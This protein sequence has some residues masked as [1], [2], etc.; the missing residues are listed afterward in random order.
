MFEKKLKQKE[1]MINNF[2]KEDI[3][4][5]FKVNEKEIE[6]LLQEY[7]IN[8][9][10]S[11]KEIRNEIVNSQIFLTQFV[12]IP[13]KNSKEPK[14]ENE[15]NKNTKTSFFNR[16]VSVLKGENE[17]EEDN[18]FNLNENEDAINNNYNTIKFT[19]EE[20]KNLYESDRKILETYNTNKTINVKFEYEKSDKIKDLLNEFFKSQ[21]PK[22]FYQK[23]LSKICEIFSDLLY[24]CF[25]SL[26]DIKNLEI[27]KYALYCRYMKC[28]M[29]I[30]EMDL[31][32]QD[33]NQFAE[34]SKEIKEMLM[35]QKQEVD[36]KYNNSLMIITQLNEEKVNIQKKCNELENELNN[37]SKKFD[38]FKIQISNE[39]NKIKKDFDIIKKE[40]DLLK[41]TLLDFKNYFMKFIGND[42][43]IIEN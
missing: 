41:G 23:F 42:G 38:D 22:N 33:L 7:I 12:K 16:F 26:K 15:K 29:K 34:S 37:S 18:I 20:F 3:Y 11:G 31:E 2:S 19:E 35:K 17:E 4:K 25:L 13:L 21:L 40:K 6:D 30:E 36:I 32:I 9:K 24:A 1:E 43:E 27:V 8:D 5:K 10:I 39:Y 28:R 14:N